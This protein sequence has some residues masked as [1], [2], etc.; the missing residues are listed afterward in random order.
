LP[1]TMSVD[2]GAAQYANAGWKLTA[3]LKGAGDL[4]DVCV[5]ARSAVTGTETLVRIPITIGTTPPPPG[6]P[7]TPPVTEDAPN[8]GSAPD[9][10]TGGSGTGGT[11]SGDTGTPGGAT[12]GGAPGSPGPG[13]GSINPEEVGPD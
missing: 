6:E 10:R 4:R 5:T 12:G 13:S 2:H 8:T 1:S 3:V 9:T 11:E 7:P